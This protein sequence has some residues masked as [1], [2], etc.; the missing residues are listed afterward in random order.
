MTQLFSRVFRKKG[1]LRE[2]DRRKI[3]YKGEKELVSLLTS[4]G[5]A[6]KYESMVEGIRRGEVEL[7]IFNIQCVTSQ[8][9]GKRE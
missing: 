3:N 1:L 2:G 5:V 9:L 8:H 7:D 4:G 6:A